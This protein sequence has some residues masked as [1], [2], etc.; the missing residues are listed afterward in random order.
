MQALN[1]AHTFYRGHDDWNRA[2]EQ[3]K[4]SVAIMQGQGR[5]VRHCS[6]RTDPNQ[7]PKPLK[8]LKPTV[9]LNK[10]ARTL[11]SRTPLMQDHENTDNKTLI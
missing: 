4:Y 5:S 2:L 3:L 7:A 11:V 9:V 6:E 8:L 10:N 1:W